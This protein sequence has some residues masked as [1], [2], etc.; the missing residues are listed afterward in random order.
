MQ[1][2]KAGVLPGSETMSEAHQRIAHDTLRAVDFV[3]GRVD[4]GLAAAHATRE[5]AIAR[6]KTLDAL[7]FDVRGS[8]ERMRFTIARVIESIF[9]EPSRGPAI[10]RHAANTL[11]QSVDLATFPDDDADLDQHDAEGRAQVIRMRDELLA[12]FERDGVTLAEMESAATALRVA[13]VQ[14]EGC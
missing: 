12:G 4:H 14:L 6:E 13:A 8:G 5:R 1:T 7:S 3:I 2:E 11:Q 9:R 10:C